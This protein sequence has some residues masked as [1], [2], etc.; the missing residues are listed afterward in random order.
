VILFF[1]YFWYREY[2]AQV[3]YNIHKCIR[4]NGLIQ[5]IR[6]KTRNCKSW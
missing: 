4:L 5:Y 2:V 3:L 1:V 6:Y